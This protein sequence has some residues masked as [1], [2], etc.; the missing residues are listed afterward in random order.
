MFVQDIKIGLRKK[1]QEN[2][3]NNLIIIYISVYIDA[4]ALTIQAMG[5]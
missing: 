4:I 3:L 2:K 5:I 1:T